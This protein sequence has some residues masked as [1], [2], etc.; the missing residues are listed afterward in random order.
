LIS[1]VYVIGNEVSAS[2][3]P[4]HSNVDLWALPRAA[5]ASM[6]WPLNNF[7]DSTLPSC[8]IPTIISTSPM[9]RAWRASG[10]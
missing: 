1:K 6:G 5:R 9:M 2:L 4:R 7:A 3:H 8:R 10:G